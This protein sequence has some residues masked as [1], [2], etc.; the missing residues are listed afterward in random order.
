MGLIAMLSKILTNRLDFSGEK[1]TVQ[2]NHIAL[3]APISL[4]AVAG[5][6][7][8]KV[9]RWQPPPPPEPR[10]P[11]HGTGHRSRY[12]RSGHYRHRTG[13]SKD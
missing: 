5:P 8:E 2:Q 1:A 4:G 11:E 10:T 6:E 3:A 7:R 9:A 13:L 12:R